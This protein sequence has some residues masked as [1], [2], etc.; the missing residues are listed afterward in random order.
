MSRHLFS[1]FCSLNL[2]DDGHDDD[3]S[4]DDDDNIQWCN[5]HRHTH[6]PRLAKSL[7]AEHLPSIGSSK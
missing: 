1:T 7:K 4:G 3:D 6:E 2:C 5:V